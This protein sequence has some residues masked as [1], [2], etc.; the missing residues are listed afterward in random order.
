M[1]GG[2]ADQRRSGKDAGEAQRGNGGDRQRTRHAGLVAG[3]REQRRCDVGAA[4]ADQHIARQRRL[5]W[6]DQG[7]H[8]HASGSKQSAEN[9]RALAAHARH[10]CIA[11]QAGDG[12]GQGEGHIADTG[13]AGIDATHIAE[14]HRAPVQHRTF[15]EE[16]NERQYADEQ[17]DAVWQGQHRCVVRHPFAVPVRR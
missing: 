2:E 10:Q 14:E 8:Q 4:K 9:D 12:H 6:R 3:Q 1:V 16:R 7:Q 13:E 11:E 17:H 5:P 15:A